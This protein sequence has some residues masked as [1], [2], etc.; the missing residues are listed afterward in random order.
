MKPSEAI[1]QLVELLA[2]Q[3]DAVDVSWE[4]AAQ[5]V[6]K[7]KKGRG[8][9]D[10]GAARQAAPGLC[11]ACKCC[12]AAIP[13]PADVKPGDPFTCPACFPSTQVTYTWMPQAA[14]SRPAGHAQDDPTF[15]RL[16]EKAEWKGTVKA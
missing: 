7:A 5:I 12:G 16:G 11:V 2:R 4:A 1:R 6:A 3:G 9:L 13:L 15:R 14:G 10:A 8:K